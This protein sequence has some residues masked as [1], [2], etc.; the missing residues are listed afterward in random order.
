MIPD[1]F[2]VKKK[3]QIL[4]AGHINRLG[5]AV[6]RIQRGLPSNIHGHGDSHSG[7]MPF[8]QR[9]VIYEPDT[10]GASANSGLVT[11]KPRYW[12]SVEEEW[13]TNEDVE[14]DLDLDAV[15]GISISDGDILTVW[16]DPLREAFIPIK[17]SSTDIYW[18]AT[19]VAQTVAAGTAATVNFNTEGPKSGN[20]WSYDATTKILTVSATF[21]AECSISLEWN[22]SGSPGSDEQESVAVYLERSSAT[23]VPR[24][25]ATAV[26]ERTTTFTGFGS[27]GRTFP[28]SIISGDTFR[29]RFTNALTGYTIDIPDEAFTPGSGAS[30]SIRAVGPIS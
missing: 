17:D 26:A 22:I 21:E 28:L 3:G 15:G 12:D 11:V 14:Y 1:K 20:V 24:S 13:T 6:N 10:D 2:P 23:T 29:V 16:W 30:W 27:L 25:N 8:E 4:G 5:D 18:S 19:N 9:L 7:L